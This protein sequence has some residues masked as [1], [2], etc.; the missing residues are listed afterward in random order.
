MRILKVWLLVWTLA[1]FAACGGGGGGGGEAAP[2]DTT[3]PTV[4]LTAPLDGATVTG[5]TQVTASA[6]DDV[7]VSRVEFYL[8]GALQGSDNAGPYSLAWDTSALARG[9]YTW[10]AKAYDAAGN[11]QQSAAV[12]VTVPIYVTMN[13]VVSGAGAVGTVSLAGLPVAAPYGLN[14][15]VTMPVGASIASVATSGPYAANGLASTS[16]P[17]TIIL[18]SSSIASGEIMTVNFAGVPAGA[19][20][21]DFAISLSAVFD[22]GGNQIQ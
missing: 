21:G 13:T 22:G 10:T 12:T 6:A 5:V 16:G 19:L 1:T 8:N 14:F 9:S 20:P 17:S 4:A 18:A 15:V 7:G 11:E 2:A 3:P